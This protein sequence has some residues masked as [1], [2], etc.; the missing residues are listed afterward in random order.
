[1]TFLAQALMLLAGLAV[2]ML[3]LT[4]LLIGRFYERSAGRRS[5]YQLFLLPAGLLA[6]AG[7]FA[8]SDQTGRA[9]SAFWLLGGGSLML[10]CF[11]LY[12]QM[13]KRSR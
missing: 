5:G 9:G 10:L 7:V 6:L 8:V 1:M 13:T 2:V 12:R 11:S 3:T 4:L